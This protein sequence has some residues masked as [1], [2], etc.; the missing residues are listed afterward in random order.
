[1][2]KTR[3]TTDYV[4]LSW[5]QVGLKACLSR[6]VYLQFWSNRYWIEDMNFNNQITREWHYMCIDRINTDVHLGR[7]PRSGEEAHRMVVESLAVDIMK[8]QMVL[9]KLHDEDIKKKFIHQWTPDIRDVNI[10][11]IV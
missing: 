8:K 1:M 2:S 9:R 4:G 3:Q 5:V 6:C 7:N 11:D 10:Y